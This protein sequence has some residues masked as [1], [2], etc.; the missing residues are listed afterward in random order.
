MS[1]TMKPY[2]PALEIQ[3]QIEL[4]G[5]DRALVVGDG[6]LGQLIA[7]TFALVGCELLV[8]GG[9]ERKLGLLANR[10]IRTLHLRSPEGVQEEDRASFDIAVEC[11][12]NP[13]GFEIAR[14]ALRP[15]GTLVMKS[16]YAGDLTLDASSIVV[17]EITLVGSRCG[18]FTPALR[19]LERREVEV[20]DLIDARFP[21]KDALAAFERAQ[22]PGALKVLVEIG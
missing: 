6:K 15:R 2:S 1:P 10:G 3:E 19:M 11:T 22:Q 16:T 7:R 8:V 18:P 20:A 21:L 5:N 9:H 12:G 14:R 17:D 13:S 4:T